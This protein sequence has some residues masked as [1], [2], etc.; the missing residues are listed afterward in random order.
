MHPALSVL[1]PVG[2][3]VV[4]TVTVA[5]A[6]TRRDLIVSV[7]QKKRMPVSIMVMTLKHC[8]TAYQCHQQY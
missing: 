5:V 8:H 7:S 6:Q 3:T 2:H 4:M 1:L